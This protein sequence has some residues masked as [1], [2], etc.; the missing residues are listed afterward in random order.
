MTTQATTTSV[1][2]RVKSAMRAAILVANHNAGLRSSR[3]FV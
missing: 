2:L 1:R 3:R